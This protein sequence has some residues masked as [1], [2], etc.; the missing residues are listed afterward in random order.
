MNKKVALFHG[1]ITTLE[2][3]AIVNAANKTL[4][5]GGGVDYLIHRGA[6]KKMDLECKMLHGC[7]TGQTKI[8]KG[9]NLPA[10]FVLHTV[11]PIDDNAD[12]LKSCYMTCLKLV[13]KHNIR[14]VAFCGVS[15]G[16][17]GFPVEA[18]SNIALNTVRKW[19]EDE[20]N[21][22]K[23]DLIIFCTFLD[24]EKTCYEQWMP[25]YFPP[26]KPELIKKKQEEKPNKEKDEEDKKRKELEQ[27]KG[28]ELEKESQE[29]EKQKL[30][31]TKKKTEQEV[32]EKSTSNFSA[33]T[34]ESSSSAESSSQSTTILAFAVVAMVSAIAF[35]VYKFTRK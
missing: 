13:E 19:L 16:I 31:V 26:Y 12:L 4:I 14:T 20:N 22:D 28:Q 24:N 29:Q 23:V 6:G 35:S 1:D 27:R 9:Y 21:R 17:Y 2:I 15:T 32:T 8:T 25:E 7:E 33:R 11:G 18:A 10:K 5:A 30:S 3:D 34:P